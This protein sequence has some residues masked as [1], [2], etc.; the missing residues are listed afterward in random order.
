VLE[1]NFRADW[2]NRKWV[3]DFTYFWT[4]QGWLYLAVVLDLPSHH[5]EAGQ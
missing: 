1:R 3:A 2:P 5:V 4:A